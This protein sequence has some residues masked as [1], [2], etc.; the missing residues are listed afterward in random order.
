MIV[1]TSFF[2]LAYFLICPSP[3]HLGL[4]SRK[5]HEIM[6]MATVV[7]VALGVAPIQQS[8]ALQI[9][10]GDYSTRVGHFSQSVD[11]RGTTHLQGRD[12]RGLPYEIVMDRHGFV[13]AIV[14]EHVVHF[15]VQEAS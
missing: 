4:R 11:S 9:V 14:G 1:V 13:E 15:R 7:A 3:Q 2:Q 8:G 6:M 10:T 12:R 5:G